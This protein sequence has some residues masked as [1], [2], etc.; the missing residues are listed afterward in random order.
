MRDES[1]PPRKHFRLKPRDFDVVNAPGSHAP[2]DSGPTDVQG[3]LQAANT[4]PPA[5]PPGPTP[6]A[7]INDVQAL[8]RDDAARVQAT[9]INELA[10]LPRRRSRRTRDYWLLVLSLNAFFGLVAFGPYR[11][12]MTLTYGIAGMII[13]TLGLTWVMW[14]VMDDY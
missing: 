14:F 5:R 3:H 11:N 12:P 8:L 7:P 4:R 9:G 2:V 13:V 1:D 10:P 6:V